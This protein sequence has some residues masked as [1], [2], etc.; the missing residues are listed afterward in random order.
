MPSSIIY[1]EGITMEDYDDIGDQFD[2]RLMEEIHVPDTVKCI[3]DKLP[4]VITSMDDWPKSSNLH[5]WT[6]DFTF[7]D[8]PI[9]I[10]IY[11]H[12][13]VAYR[14]TDIEIGVKGN[15]CSFSCALSYIFDYDKGD[16]YYNLLCLYFLMYGKRITKMYPSPRRHLMSKYGGHMT[17]IDYLATIKKIN[18]SYM[19]NSQEEDEGSTHHIDL[20]E[21][22]N[23]YTE[24]SIGLGEIR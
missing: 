7:D 8:I 1:L 22:V 12:G 15:F 21:F 16:G 18:S 20:H 17:E 19:S 11:I 4:Q 2:T 6:C 13:D 23:I 24:D 14:S 9:Y 5:C 3:Y 10:P